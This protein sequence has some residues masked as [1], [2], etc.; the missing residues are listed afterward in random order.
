MVKTLGGS[1]G[2]AVP[3]YGGESYLVAP[4]PRHEDCQLYINK[5]DVLHFYGADAE[6]WATETFLF[7]DEMLREAALPWTSTVG[8]QQQVNDEAR[9]AWVWHG[10]ILPNN[11][12]LFCAPPKAGKTTLIFDALE[13]IL[14]GK[15][16]LGLATRPANILYVTQEAAHTILNR[17]ETEMG[18]LALTYSKRVHWMTRKPG[19]SWQ[20][21][22]LDIADYVATYPD[23]LVV[24]DT[25]AFW[26]EIE[27]EN[28]ASQV[29][30]ALQPIVDLARQNPVSVLLI[31]HSRKFAGGAGSGGCRGSSALTGNVDIIVALEKDERGMGGTANSN[32]KRMLTT[33]SRYGETP[34][35]LAIIWE[36]G[37]RYRLQ[38]EEDEV[39]VAVENLR[40]QHPEVVYLLSTS[41]LSIRAIAEQTEVSKSVVGRIAQLVR[42]STGTDGDTMS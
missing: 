40:E 9:L 34:P 10:Y 21:T 16:M 26:M 2:E 33:L 18:S 37:Q 12:T 1:D 7:F 8:L 42:G 11:L 6:P 31:H 15:P 29:R 20:S 32:P 4:C 5:N 24:I 28:D 36:R 19:L 39:K 17:I 35:A 3:I 23:S 41:N 27:D 30:A 25:M 38:G 13:A 14:A 22:A